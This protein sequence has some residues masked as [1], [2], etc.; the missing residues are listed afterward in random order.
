MLVPSLGMACVFHTFPLTRICL[1]HGFGVFLYFCF[2]L[3]ILGKS[4]FGNWLFLKMVF[5]YYRNTNFPDLEILWIPSSW[6]WMFKNNDL[7]MF[8][9]LLSIILELTCHMACDLHG[10]LFTE[11]IKK[12]MN[13]INSHTF[14]LS[15]SIRS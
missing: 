9:I 2:T 13:V 12:L 14:P 6:P 15:F 7:R 1:H 5:L 3:N 11:T 4:S 8:C 10:F